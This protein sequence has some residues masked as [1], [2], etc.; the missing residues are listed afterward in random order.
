MTQSEVFLW[1]HSVMH[2]NR[3][4]KC[5]TQQRMKSG[6]LALL[7]LMNLMKSTFC[8]TLA[9]SIMAW[10]VMKA[11]IRPIPSLGEG[12]GVS[13]LVINTMSLTCPQL[14]R[15][16]HQVQV[17]LSR[18]YGGHHLSQGGH[19]PL[20]SQCSGTGKPHDSVRE[21]CCLAHN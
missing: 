10:M 8:S 15:G 2:G 6:H 18:R 12:G 11:L 9:I 16:H 5:L 14:S 17:S 13:V 19:H 20:A 4:V 21:W 7:K 3:R 1:I